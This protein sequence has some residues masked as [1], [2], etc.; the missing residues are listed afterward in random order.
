MK[1]ILIALFLLI[2]AHPLIAENF[3]ITVETALREKAQSAL[4][5]IYGSGNFVVDVDIDVTAP[6]Y[7]VKYTEQST[8]KLNS[9][10][11]NSKVNLLPGY[12]VIKNL[13]PSNLNQLPFDSITTYIKPRILR[14]RVNI[15]VNRSFSRSQAGRAQALLKD[16][17]EIKNNRDKLTVTYQPF[18]EADELRRS[19]GNAPTILDELLRL[20]RLIIFGTIFWFTILFGI[21]VFIAIRSGN[22]SKGDG[23]KGSIAPSVNINP[24]IEIPESQSAGGSSINIDTKVKRYFD[25]ISDANIDDLIYLLKK[26]SVSMENVSIIVSYLP[27]KLGAKVLSELDIENQ[28]VVTANILGQRLVNRPYLD[29]LEGKIRDWIECL[30]GG[31]SNFQK[32]FNFV[33]GEVKKKLLVIL[34]KNNPDA[35]QLFR[36]FVIIFEDLKFMEDEEMKLVLSDANVE[37]LSTALVGVDEET[38]SKVNTNLAQNAKEMI[39][40]YLDLKAQTISKQDIEAAQDYVLGIVDKLEA[41]GKVDLRG[42]VRR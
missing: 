17:L 14:K 15:I 27:S 23:D 2:L 26:E 37:L 33:S 10:K 16:L 6:G 3:E 39:R 4:D 22:A 32:L 12:P 25:F 34:S 24:N 9:K 42:K 38:Q 20:D 35:Y 11:T 7:K 5:K 29:K 19:S 30:V 40:Q 28:A 1:K 41:E 13:G 31:E 36:E 21:Y 18:Y 8:P